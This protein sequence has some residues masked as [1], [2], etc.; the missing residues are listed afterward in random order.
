MTYLHIMQGNISLNKYQYR[1]YKKQQV[2]ASK[3]TIYVHCQKIYNLFVWA[4][5][6]GR[7]WALLIGT[8]LGK[9]KQHIFPVSDKLYGIEIECGRLILSH[10]V[11]RFSNKMAPYLPGECLA[12][13]ECWLSEG[14]QLM[15]GKEEHLYPQ[16]MSG[17]W[18]KKAL[19]S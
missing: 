12:Y 7:R 17:N 14:K 11:N 13:Q 19:K 16:A 4:L 10:C 6:T 2:T 15:S 8:C 1:L 5:E 18:W 9:A 3:Y